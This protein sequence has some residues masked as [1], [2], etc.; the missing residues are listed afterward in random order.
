M[1]CQSNINSLQ[2]T[3]PYSFEVMKSAIPPSRQAIP[4]ALYRHTAL[5][6][7]PDWET[8][9]YCCTNKKGRSGNYYNQ[10]MK[11]ASS[12]EVGVVL[13]VDGCWPRQRLACSVCACSKEVPP[14]TSLAFSEKR[15]EILES[16]MSEGAWVLLVLVEDQ[17]T[18]GSRSRSGLILPNV[19][20][21]EEP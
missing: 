15:G 16:E 2:G 12:S 8:P 13:V 19:N 5:L 18:L 1:L 14:Q 17:R 3:P 21:Y 6:R 20:H 10:I 9:I 4:T 7:P 11:V